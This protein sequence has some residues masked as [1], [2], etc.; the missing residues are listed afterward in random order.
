MSPEFLPKGTPSD[1]IDS[2][3][4]EP[5]VA[6][7]STGR[8]IDQ[9]QKDVELLTSKARKQWFSWLNFSRTKVPSSEDGKMKLPDFVCKTLSITK[10]EEFRELISYLEQKVRDTAYVYVPASKRDKTV[11]TY[12]RKGYTLLREEE[13]S[14]GVFST[15][16]EIGLSFERPMKFDAAMT[17]ALL[18]IFQG[19]EQPLATIQ[20]LNDMGVQFTLSDLKADSVAMQHLRNGRTIEEFLREI[21]QLPFDIS[22]LRYLWRI[23]EAVSFYN[24]LDEA[25]I[26]TMTAIAGHLGCKVQMD[27]S[28]LA[29]IAG[30]PIALDVLKR[31]PPGEG[32]ETIR[33]L[34]RCSEHHSYAALQEVL[35]LCPSLANTSCASFARQLEVPSYSTLLCDAD[36]RLFVRGVVQKY[37]VEL[38]HVTLERCLSLNKD[39]NAWGVVESFCEEFCE[40]H[41]IARNLS[42]RHSY[43]AE[44]MQDAGK[45]AQLQDPEFLRFARTLKDSLGYQDSLWRLV[46]PNNV[47]QLWQDPVKRAQCLEEETLRLGKHF[48]HGD[49]SKQAGDPTYWD[50]VLSLRKQYPLL[51]QQLDTLK[52]DFGYTAETGM[53][54]LLERGDNPS[55]DQPRG[56]GELSSLRRFIADEAF[57]STFTSE[58]AQDNAEI[59]T[60]QT[61]YEMRLQD[62]TFLDSVDFAQGDGRIVYETATELHAAGIEFHP[63]DQWKL[64][65]AIGRGQMTKIFIDLDPKTRDFVLQ[66]LSPIIA[67]PQG[68]RLD[69]IAIFKRLSH[70]PSQELQLLKNELATQ[71][72]ML[73]DPFTAYERIATLFERNNLPLIG[74]LNAAFSILYPPQ[75]IFE[76]MKSHTSPRLG[77]AANRMDTTENRADQL[78]S[79][80]RAT[81][82]IFYRDLLNIHVRSGENSLHAFALAIEQ[83]G[84]VLSKLETNGAGALST[85][86]REQMHYLL[87]KL[88]TLTQ[89]SHT[90]LQQ[91]F[92]AEGSADKIQERY[93][94]VR[95]AMH[96]TEGQTVS[97]RVS[98]MFLRPLGYE[99]IREMLQDMDAIRSTTDQRN[100]AFADQHAESGLALHAG[101]LLHGTDGNYVG[102]ILQS[103]LTAG[104]FFGAGKAHS[105]LTPFD[106]DFSKVLPADV[107]DGH[108]LDTALQAS[109]AT[110]YV[111]KAG[112][113]G[114][115]VLVCDRGQFE[116]TR[117]YAVPDEHAPSDRNRYEQ[118]STPEAGER[119][120]GV[121]TGLPSSE[122]DAFIVQNGPENNRKAFQELT[123]HIVERGFYIPVFDMKGTLVF[124]PEQYDALRRN[125]TGLTDRYGPDFL[126]A[127][128]RADADSSLREKNARDIQHFTDMLRTGTDRTPQVS[129][130]VQIVLKDALTRNGIELKNP[131]DHSLGGAR[132][133]DIGSTGRGTHLLGGG[134]D[135]DYTMRIDDSGEE[136]AFN[137]HMDVV[138]MLKKELGGNDDS[139]ELHGGGYQLRLGACAI[140]GETVDIDIAIMPNSEVDYLTSHEAVE[141]RLEWI[142]IHHGEEAYLETKANILLAK[143]QLKAGKA[144]KKVEDGGFGGIGVENWILQNGGSFVEA[145]RTFRSAAYDTNGERVP[146]DEF[147]NR[148][149]IVNPG[150]NFRDKQHDDYI[151]YLKQ[152]GYDAM[153]SVVERYVGEGVVK[154]E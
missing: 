25:S 21:D 131:Q 97:D 12:N 93:N 32:Y 139:H 9:N 74:K 94:A 24:Q 137:K 150:V 75:R 100:R 58:R 124:S 114:V 13:E 104:E 115:I 73:D 17:T 106:A 116:I 51:G 128:L 56:V 88:E 119:H 140:G 141:K 112:G 39:R 91:G 76:K 90:G 107:S 154:T 121:R 86:E 44:L 113:G 48:F 67:M 19:F 142:R 41:E 53:L 82:H 28:V 60:T 101:D 89:Y 46:S 96:A 52:Q 92:I 122:L 145:C 146:L 16:G 72:I 135:F 144:Y 95:E 33:K 102:K 22:D 130:T 54:S 3:Q 110:E 84:E 133:F 8:T 148:Y 77:S 55:S 61:S 134:Y 27:D 83:G 6:E 35:I 31:L 30:D 4:I 69:F 42:D 132:M 18:P 129:A 78:A 29:K 23:T 127:R 123:L 2:E 15:N 108:P 10:Q 37:G 65:Q 47:V 57:R 117:E 36:A 151:R 34:R 126:L 1:A 66:Y 63:V 71:L 105:D 87:L 138:A 80:G 5:D 68:K 152:T 143:S 43:L 20:R 26:R 79:F 85:K 50:I 99:T 111:G 11:S 120:Y 40:D 98:Q 49:V 62:I 64:L 153:L 81:S 59:L 109:I 149:S 118:F 45:V 147:K 103:G 125:Y 38:S 70:S 7:I 136:S 14:G